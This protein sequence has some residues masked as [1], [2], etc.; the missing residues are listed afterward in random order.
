[1][2]SAVV[3]PAR[4]K[5]VLITGASSGLGR[6]AAVRLAEHGYR[7][8]AG[9][10]T[11]SSSAVLAALPSSPGELIPVMLDVTDAASISRAGTQ[12]ERACVDTGLWGVVNNAG[13]AVSSPL[14]C[15]PL[16]V[17]RD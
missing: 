2:R 16:D 14:E 11:E 12:L 5:S 3:T 6:A 13:I 4:S 15:L 10:R 1:M 7:V 9:V 8:F 17:L